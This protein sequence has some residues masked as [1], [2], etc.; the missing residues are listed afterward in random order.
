MG[1][2][3][4]NWTRFGL[5]LV[6]AGVVTSLSDWLFFGVIF[7]DKYRET[8]NV[9]RTTREGTKIMWSTILAVLGAA[10]FL[11]MC[12]RFQVHSLR[13]AFGAALGV[14]VAAALPVT[15]TN[16]LYVRHAPVLAVSHAFGWL[17]RLAIAGTAYAL[18]ME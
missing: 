3:Q 18:L 5:A 6:A 15:V 12:D 9:W 16:A 11:L 2:I 1:A 13:G 4:M 17:A 8:P 10:S 7:H 14:W